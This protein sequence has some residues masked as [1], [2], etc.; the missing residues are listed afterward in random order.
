MLLIDAKGTDAGPS[1]RQLSVRN[2][3]EDYVYRFD[4][5]IKCRQG[6]WRQAL[7]IIVLWT[8]GDRRNYDRQSASL[9]RR[10]RVIVNAQMFEYIDRSGLFEI[11]LH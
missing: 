1:W 7:P 2:R 3:E 6:V 4:L 5:P 9:A 10:N 11:L 8:L